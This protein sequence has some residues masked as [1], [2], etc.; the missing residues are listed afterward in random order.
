MNVDKSTRAEGLPGA[1]T[2]GTLSTEGQLQCSRLMQIESGNQESRS[3]VVEMLYDVTSSANSAPFSSEQVIMIQLQG[4]GQRLRA[5]S[6]PSESIDLRDSGGGDVRFNRSNGA[7]QEHDDPVSCHAAQGELRGRGR[8]GRVECQT[9]RP[10]WV[11]RLRSVT[12]P[13]NFGVTTAN[14]VWSSSISFISRR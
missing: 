4:V 10:E 3:V 6:L 14:E 8:G 11:S 5:R 1:V 9:W 2:H 7:G 12:M 13:D